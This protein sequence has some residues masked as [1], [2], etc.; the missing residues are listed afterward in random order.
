MLRENAC[1]TQLQPLEVFAGEQ[2]T[3][4]GYGENTL[5]K[6]CW[7]ELTIH[8]FQADEGARCKDTL[9]SPGSDLNSRS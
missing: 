7:I 3:L 6:V 9:P 8:P 5:P 2:H 4:N 1:H